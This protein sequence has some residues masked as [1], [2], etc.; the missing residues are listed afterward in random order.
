MSHLTKHSQYLRSTT[1]ILISS[2]TSNQHLLDS[3]MEDI[4][5]EHLLQEMNRLEESVLGL[6]QCVIR[7][8][9]KVR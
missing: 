6:Q 1:D 3:R 7:L 9:H 4:R 5:A 8:K 2:I